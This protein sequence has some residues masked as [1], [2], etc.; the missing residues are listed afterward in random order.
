[1]PLHITPTLDHA[2]WAE[3][4]ELYRLT[5]GPRDPEVLKS[6]FDNSQHTLFAYLDGRLVGAVR[7][8]ADGSDAALICDMVI[9]PELQGGGHGRT[10]LEALLAE[11]QGHR[12]VLLYASAGKEGFYTRHGF[13][14]LLTGMG[15]FADEALA[16]R[17]GLIPPKSG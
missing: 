5:L 11:L 10:L 14:P 13:S 16:Q 1:M 9:H 2:T 4:A 8:L 7:A 17:M 6:R 12:K 15:L 3:L